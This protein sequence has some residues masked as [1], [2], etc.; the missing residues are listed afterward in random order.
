MYRHIRPLLFL[1]VLLGMVLA[2]VPST[3]AN[4]SYD[5]TRVAAHVYMLSG[6]IGKR[7]AGTP[8]EA[9]AAA[10][11][12]DE[13]RS[14]GLDV[15]LQTFSAQDLTSQNVVATLPGVDPNYGTLYIGAHYDS[16]PASPGANDNASGTAVLLETARLLSTMELSP[17][18]TFVAFGAEEIGLEGS[19]A[20]VEALTPLERVMADGMVNMDCVG[21]G[22]RQVISTLQDRNRSLV[23]RMAEVAQAGGFVVEVGSDGGASD[24]QPF[25]TAGIPAAFIYTRSTTS[26]CGPNYHSPGDTPNTVMPEQM[27]RV[28]QIVVATLQDAAS[29][30]TLRSPTQVWLPVVTGP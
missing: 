26:I 22:D 20:F 28:G 7:A 18:L 8:A 11:I 19:Q 1:L 29:D 3:T 16:V 9:Q 6:T 25:A 4:I 24:H 2:L 21:L 12:A 17:T 13:M 15:S 10:Y 23:D 5:R 27:E 14:Y 30:A